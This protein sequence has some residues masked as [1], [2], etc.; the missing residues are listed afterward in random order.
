MRIDTLSVQ[1]KFI[2]ENNNMIIYET[3]QYISD[4]NEIKPL[5]ELIGEIKKEFVDNQLIAIKYLNRELN[6]N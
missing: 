2:C 6:C 4:P 1:H 5:Y 3:T